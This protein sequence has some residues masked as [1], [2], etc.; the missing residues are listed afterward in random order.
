MNRYSLLTLAISLMFSISILTSSSFQKISSSAIEVQ[1]E[2][3]TL[4]EPEENLAQA[5]TNLFTQNINNDIR[6]LKLRVMLG[7]TYCYDYD[8][9][10]AEAANRISY[11][12][13]P[14]INMWS[15]GFTAS[16]V[17]ISPLPIDYC[18][19]DIMTLCNDN[20]C[21]SGCNNN[22][23]DLIH[24][25][26][27]V[28]NL[29]KVRHDISDPNYDIFMTLVSTTMCG[30]FN[31][32]HQEGGIFGVTYRGD[33]HALVN[34]VSITSTNMRV[35]IM[36]HE[37]SHMFYCKDGVCSPNYLCIMNGGYDG[38]SLYSTNIW[39][40]TCRN[41]FTPTAH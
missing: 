21:G 13:I 34:N 2:P 19:F 28:K 32:N 18:N 36:Q 25:K 39:C 11:V 14:F 37:I 22:I 31:N 9:E 29:N 8:N 30:I 23:N 1:N 7:N 27:S 33:N 26:N 20:D 3:I 40:P 17:N 6:Y 15:I 41:D 16:F 24:H 38:M 4:I 12:D 10:Y 5:N 35:R